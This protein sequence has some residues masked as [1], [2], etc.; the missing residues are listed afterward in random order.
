M[1]KTILF[2]LFLGSLLILGNL[3]QAG[4]FSISFGTGWG[5]HAQPVY[6]ERCE[7]AVVVYRPY[8]SHYYY[9]RPYYQ[10]PAYHSYGYAQGYRQG[11][12]HGYATAVRRA[13][14]VYR[15]ERYDRVYR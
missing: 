10:R 15:A 7:P 3:S 6:Y 13:V 14:P 11:F 4:N 5:Y 2:A 12:R 1:K 8:S 9:H